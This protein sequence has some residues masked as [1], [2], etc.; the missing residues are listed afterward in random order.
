MAESSGVGSALAVL[1]RTWR[2]R[3]LLTQ[4]QLATRT[5]LG[6]RTIRRL[7]ADGLR[8][9]R[10]ESM[11]LLADALDLTVAERAQL[12]AA[13]RDR[14]AMFGQPRQLPAPPQVFTGR[15]E[16]LAD[17]DCFRDISTVVI[18]AID[19]M[20]GIGKTAL[21]LHAAHRLLDRYPD[22]QLFVDLH[23]YTQGMAPVEP[24]E[25][26]D[27]ML[28]ALGVPG[29]QIPAQLDA[30]AAL[31]RSRLAD[32]QMLILLDNAATEAQVQPLLP[33]TPGCRVLVTSRRRLTGL[34]H[35]HTVSLD[36]LPLPDAV[37]L[38]TST[39]GE[40]RLTNQPPELL[41]ETV[42]LCG[43]LPLAIRIAAA[44]LGSHPTWSVTYLVERLRD[45][46]HRLAELGAGQRSVTA[47]LDLS[48]QQ[49][50]AGQQ[51]IY[52]LLGLHPGPD[53]DPY[54]AARP[55]QHHHHPSKAVARPAARRP[56]AAGTRPRPVRLSRPGPRPRHRHRRVRA[57]SEGGAVP[58]AGPLPAHRIVGDGHRLFVRTRASSPGPARWHTHP[59]PA[60]TDPG[61]RVARHRA[62]QPARRGAARRR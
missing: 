18:T 54:A 14:P 49:L 1:L 48:Y 38:F 40:D 41:A 6:V 17:L 19:G 25:A 46:Q 26:L 55:C 20:A 59:R 12:T 24:G 50:T 60:R 27:R 37:T 62:A 28:H 22:G 42:E 3:A 47:A 32:Q 44:R 34:D 4:E 2:E 29:E 56:P 9:P 43:R 51:G 10:T 13:A 61:D 36:V 30:R 45:H 16:E 11:R 7:E 23:G 58:A 15:A 21:A 39:T 5:G 52:R 8:R 53:L 35:T 57:R 33:G 31:Y